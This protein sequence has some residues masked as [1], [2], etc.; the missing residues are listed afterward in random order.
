MEEADLLSDNVIVMCD[1][2]KVTN[3]TPLDLK[4][5]YGKV[6]QFSIIVNN[7]A[8]KANVLKKCHEVFSTDMNFVR[9]NDN[10]KDRVDLEI[11]S[12]KDEF[13][14]SRGV[15]ISKIHT[16]I[17]WVEK[18]DYCTVNEIGSF[19]GSL[20]EVFLS[21]TDDYE[22]GVLHSTQLEGQDQREYFDQSKHGPSIYDQV[23]ALLKFT[24][25]RK[26]HRGGIRGSLIEFSAYITC[27][28]CCLGFPALARD[29]T[30]NG[31]SKYFLLGVLSFIFLSNTSLGYKDISLGLLGFMERRGLKLKSYILSFWIHSFLVQFIVISLLSTMLYL[32]AML[33][34]DDL[35][36]YSG[37]VIIS[38]A[39]ASNITA[40]EEDSSSLRADLA[41]FEKLI[42]IPFIFA[43]ATSGSDLLLLSFVSSGGKYNYMRFI[44]GISL[45]LIVPYIFF[46]VSDPSKDWFTTLKEETFKGVCPESL[47]FSSTMTAEEVLNCIYL[48]LGLDSSLYRALA[49][50]KYLSILPAVGA[51]QGIFLSLCGVVR[52]DYRMHF[53]NEEFYQGSRFSFPFAEKQYRDHLQYFLYGALFFNVIGFLLFIIMKTPLRKTPKIEPSH[54][55]HPRTEEVAYEKE[56]VTGIIQPILQEASSTYEELEGGQVVH[57]FTDANFQQDVYNSFPP[58]LTYELQKVYSTN[59]RN[60]KVIAL[61]SLDLA[62]PKGEICGKH[63]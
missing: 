14:R 10:I 40:L 29:A 45:L 55:Y 11:G 25:R 52:L 46:D 51:F 49:A 9:L 28:L 34:K 21:I 53:F 57:N 62:I 56:K 48:N 15:E 50:S 23:F 26:W 16:L 13:H 17:T 19:S 33:S 39:L 47:E 7:N 35:S 44:S 5:R 38:N 59:R 61:K 20:E 43:F 8:M 18:E 41:G 54:E 12:I 32:G 3:G 58:I 6:F 60:P 27:L 30:Y 1:G 22:D 63:A 36:K 24:M 4:A 2:K 31:P 37:T 42:P